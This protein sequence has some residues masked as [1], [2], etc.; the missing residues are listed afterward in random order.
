MF[1]KSS[2]QT[3]IPRRSS[4]CLAGGESFQSGSAY[5][6][7]LTHLE[8]NVE[9]HDYCLMC[10][11]AIEKEQRLKEGVY[12]IGKIPVKR[13]KSSSQDSKALAL[14][15]QLAKKPT[16]KEKK[17]LMVLTLYLERQKQI[18][19]RS[20]M[21]NKEHPHIHYYELLESGEVFSIETCSLS[22]EDSER[23]VYE[24]KEKFNEP[25]A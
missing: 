6:S 12:W 2:F 9:R 8:E 18:E 24:L 22:Q 20:E 13:E 25:D 7:Y 23:M 21:K 14:F 4:S 11:T 5:V 15:C 3:S 1:L 17:L 16:E 19:R 10:W